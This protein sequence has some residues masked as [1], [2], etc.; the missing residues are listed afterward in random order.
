M[1]SIEKKID[2]SYGLNVTMHCN[3]NRRYKTED[4]NLDYQG[5]IGKRKEKMDYNSRLVKAKKN[6]LNNANLH[7]PPLCNLS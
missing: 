1:G 5:K 2:V 7:G 6:L 4:T 3:H